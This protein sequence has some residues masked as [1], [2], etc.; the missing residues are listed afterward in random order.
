MSEDEPEP[1][2]DPVVVPIEDALDLHPFAPRDVPDVVADYLDA[3]HAAGFAEVR[4]I[5]GKGIGVQRRRV[6]AVLA[7]HP[8]VVRFADAPPERGGLGAT[9]VWLRREAT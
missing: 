7:S 5:H 2:D 9:Q 8:L 4:L 6:Q 3:A 1:V